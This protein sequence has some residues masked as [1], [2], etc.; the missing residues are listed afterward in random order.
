[1]PLPVT[2]AP[3]DLSGGDLASAYLHAFPIAPDDNAN[4]AILPR[5][6]WVGA[7]GTLTVLDVNENQVTFVGVPVGI[8]PFRAKRVLLT[9][10]SA[11]Q[12]LGLY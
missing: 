8:F 12:L 7:A 2:P 11:G 6:I 1:M 5:V 9:G 3:L 4:L 10:T